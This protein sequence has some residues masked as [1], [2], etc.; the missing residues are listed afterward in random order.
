MSV[1]ELFRYVSD[2][3]TDQWEK[4]LVAAGVLMEKFGDDGY[5]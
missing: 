5:D 1:G 3:V 4:I 2:G